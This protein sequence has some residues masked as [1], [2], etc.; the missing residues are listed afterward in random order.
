MTSPA[1]EVSFYPGGIV[2]QLTADTI[3]GLIIANSHKRAKSPAMC[4][5]RFGIWQRYDWQDYCE[6]VKNFSLGLVQMGLKRGDVVCIIG[7]NE[8]EWF[9]GEF[10]VQAAGAIATG[11]FVDSIPSELKYIME[12]S[13]ASIAI[14]NDQ[15]QVDKFLQI[16]DEL[17]L[18]R[19]IV[20]WD[21]KGLKNYDELQRKALFLNDRAQV[22]TTIQNSRAA[23]SPVL[24]DMI[25]DAPSNVQFVS[26]AADPIKA[27]NFT[28]QGA[29]VSE[30]DA[31][32]FKDKLESSSFFKDVVFK[33]STTS[34]TE[35]NKLTFT[36]EF[37]LEHASTSQAVK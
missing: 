2:A 9:W 15:E 5:K 6:K 28:L 36:L 24:Q 31:I 34:K 30:R 33:S 26:L 4:M 17:P 3:P 19:K 20:Y 18:L 10:S 13:G 8:P 27:P 29:T 12:H 1:R 14:A 21:P 22:V 23:W 7:D 32:K 25:N 11:T 16:K 37:N 35:S